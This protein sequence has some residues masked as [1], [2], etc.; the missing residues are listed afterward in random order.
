MHYNG[1]FLDGKVFDSSIG[2]QP[3]TF[4]LTN[5]IPGWIEGLQLM[6]KGGK[7]K[8]IIPSNLAYGQGNQGIPPFSTLLFDVELIDIKSGK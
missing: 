1:T 5:V 3:A 2:K 7:S 6:K 8:L 4:V